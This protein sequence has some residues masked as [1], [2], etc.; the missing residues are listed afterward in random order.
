M[1]Y[2]PLKNHI[3]E[4]WNNRNHKN[5]HFV[6]YEDLQEDIFGELKKLN[7]FLSTG[8]SDAQLNNVSS[9]YKVII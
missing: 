2:S 5:L 1:I 9:F 7:N 4:G 3:D 8:L 6:F